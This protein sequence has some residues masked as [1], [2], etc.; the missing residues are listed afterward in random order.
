MNDSSKHYWTYGACARTGAY[1]AGRAKS[2]RAQDIKES[3]MVGF[4]AYFN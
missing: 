1:Y 3:E 4:K 2:Y